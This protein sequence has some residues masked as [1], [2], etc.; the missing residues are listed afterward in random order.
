MSRETT[1]MSTSWSEAGAVRKDTALSFR[2]R[3]EAGRI[4]SAIDQVMS[5]IRLSGCVRG[6]EI[7]VEL[8]LHEALHNAV[9]HGNRRN[10]EKWVHV[11]CACDPGLGV[12]IVVRDEGLGFDPGRIEEVARHRGLVLRG[13]GLLIMRSYMD[14][15]WFEK[16][17]SE[18][19]LFK[20]CAERALYLSPSRDAEVSAPARLV[21]ALAGT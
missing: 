21:P 6:Q 16:G 11:R 19:H 3:S 5:L 18:V 10:P 7:Q 4:A 15:V 13:R 12:S 17:G 1:A 8:A 2:F 9:V 20:N 14:L